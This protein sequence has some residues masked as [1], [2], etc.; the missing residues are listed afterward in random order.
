MEL[1]ARGLDNAQVAA[2]L[3][4]AEKTVRNL[5]TAVFLK[6]EAESRAQAIVR[7]REAGFGTG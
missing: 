3:G 6:L 4:L 1:L 7:A 2:R 5:V